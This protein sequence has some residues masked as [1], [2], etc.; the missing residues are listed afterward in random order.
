MQD[1]EN[2]GPNRRAE[3]CKTKS[4][5]KQCVSYAAKNHTRESLLM[6]KIAHETTNS[7]HDR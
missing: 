6:P 2:N 5:V 1:L 4:F 7:E 3:K